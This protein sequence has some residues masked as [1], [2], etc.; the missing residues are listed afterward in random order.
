[1]QEYAVC[2]RTRIVLSSIVA[3]SQ[4]LSQTVNTR[5]EMPVHPELEYKERWNISTEVDHKHRQ[6][7]ARALYVIR[8]LSGFNLVVCV[9]VFV[10]V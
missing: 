4:E 1:M 10:Y 6:E 9:C 8:S 2:V 3:V 7:R 5:I